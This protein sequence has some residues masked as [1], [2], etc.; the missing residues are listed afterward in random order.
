VRKSIEPS[1]PP[2]APNTTYFVYD[3]DDIVLALRSNGDLV[4]RYLHGPAVDEILAD[5]NQYGGVLWSLRDQFYNVRDLVDHAGGHYNHIDYDAFGNVN[6]E[7]KLASGGHLVHA[8]GFQSRERDQESLLNY[9]RNRYYDAQ[10]GRWRSEDPI[11]FAAGDENLN[12]FVANMVLIAIDPSGLEL[13]PRREGQLV[14]QFIGATVRDSNPRYETFLDREISTII[15]QTLRKDVPRDRSRPD[16]VLVAPDIKNTLARQCGPAWVYEIKPDTPLWIP[17]GMLKAAYYV[18]A[19][20]SHGLRAYL[21][22][23]RHGGVN[24]HGVVPMVGAITWR[25]AGNGVIAYQITTSSPTGPKVQ[26]PIPILFPPQPVVLPIPLL[27]PMFPNVQ[28]APASPPVPVAPRPLPVDP[29]P[30]PRPRGPVGV[31]PIRIRVP[32][33]PPWLFPP[34]IS[35]PG[36]PNAIMA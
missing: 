31:P 4:N 17:V 5:E 32:L 15:R 7:M 6:G 25:F 29:R 3:T 24:G 21:G 9:H 28:P 36:D 16:I 19:L 30:A 2:A 10:I 27:P 33:I 23:G 35:H 1:V 18:G 11:G 34:T 8:Y 12:R 20:K 26:T 14:H 13:T 22:H